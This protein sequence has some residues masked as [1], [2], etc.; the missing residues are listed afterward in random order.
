MLCQRIDVF[1]LFN[2]DSTIMTI[3]RIISGEVL[4]Y[5]NG[6]RIRGDYETRSASASYFALTLSL[7]WVMNSN[8]LPSVVRRWQIILHGLY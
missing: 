1:G 5:R 7:K 4:K 3:K 6:L 2:I 8:Y